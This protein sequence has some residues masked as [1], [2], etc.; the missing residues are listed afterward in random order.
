MGIDALLMTREQWPVTS[1]SAE[2]LV[3]VTPQVAPALGCTPATA[4]TEANDATAARDRD[5]DLVH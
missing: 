2:R 3:G 1:S 4:V 5:G